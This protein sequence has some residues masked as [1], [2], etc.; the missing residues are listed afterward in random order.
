MSACTYPSN[1]S[2]L[3]ILRKVRALTRCCQ[4]PIGGYRNRP[5][6]PASDGH[7]V[8]TDGPVCQMTIGGSRL[9]NASGRY[10]RL[11]TVLPMPNACHR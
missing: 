9:S 5:L 11:P 3:A 1:K 2:L 7:F 6:E 8:L 10:F 4:W